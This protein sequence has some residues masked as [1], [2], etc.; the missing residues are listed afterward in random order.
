MEITKYRKS[1]PDWLKENAL[2]LCPYCG[3]FI[4]NN[5]SLT[6]RWCANPNCPGHM[7]YKLVELAKYFHVDGI[8][9]ATALRIVK[10]HQL[11]NHFEIIPH[12]FPNAKPKA[13]LANIA[14]LACIEGYGEIA[15]NNELSQYYTFE[16]YFSYSYINPLLLPYKQLLIDAQQYF[17]LKRPLSASK[18]Y[19]MATGSFHGFQSRDD[20]F[21]GV[22]EAFGSVVHVIQTGKRKTGISYLIKEPDAADHTKSAIAMEQGIPIVSPAEFVAILQKLTN[23]FLE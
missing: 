11:K 18:L 3:A 8:G 7:S 1:L 19:V 9:P 21:R 4:V 10:E 2:M 5:E 13:S 16:Q 15:A 6:A 17:A 22:N 12:W 20:F 23:I 14:C